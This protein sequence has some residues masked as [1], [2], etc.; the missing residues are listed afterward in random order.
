MLGAPH[1]ARNGGLSA[2]RDSSINPLMVSITSQAILFCACPQAGIERGALRGFS[3]PFTDPLTPSHCAL[4]GC[5]THAKPHSAALFL[6]LQ[7]PFQRLLVVPGFEQFAH[8]ID[9]AVDQEQIIRAGPEP[10]SRFS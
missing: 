4:A 1:G 5:S 7:Q 10:P 8:L 3:R 6:Q 9:V 2:T